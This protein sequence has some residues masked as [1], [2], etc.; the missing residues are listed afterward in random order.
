MQEIKRLNV[1]SVAKMAGITYGAISLL[2]IPFI[3]I[4][5]VAGALANARAETGGAAGG[6]AVVIM[7]IM[8]LIFPVIY[9]LMGFLMGA[10]MAF[11]Y[12]LVAE[13]FGGVQ[14]ELSAAPPQPIAIAPQ[15][16]P[17]AMM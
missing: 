4:F 10:L 17:A 3:F 7:A 13:K 15:P 8:A 12:N 6:V 2:L 16:S 1:L 14:F 5:G 11:V 9:G